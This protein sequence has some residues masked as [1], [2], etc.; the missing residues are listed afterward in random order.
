MVHSIRK[1]KTKGGKYLLGVFVTIFILYSLSGIV[2]VISSR[3]NLIKGEGKKLHINEFFNLWNNEKQASYRSDIDAKQVAYINS[4]NFM[5][6]FLNKLVNSKL[7]ELE[8]EKFAIREPD[9]LV[10]KAISEDEFFRVDG[11]F[12]FGKFEDYLKKENLTELDLMERIREIENRKFLVST[13][14]KVP[15]LNETGVAVLSEESNLSKNLKIFSIKKSKLKVNIPVVTDEEIKRYY[16]Y[17]TQKFTAPE[18]KKID[19]VKITDCKASQFRKLQEIVSPRSNIRDVSKAMKASIESL[20]YLSESEILNN[21]KYSGIIG[22]F[23]I[24]LD[25]LSR[26]V[27]VGNDAYVYS[28]TGVKKGYVKNLKEVEKDIALVIRA[29]KTIEFQKKVVLGY[30]EEYKNKKFADEALLSHGFEIKKVNNL[31]RENS[32]SL[33]SDFLQQLMRTGDKDTTDVFQ[34]DS[35]LY[36]ALITDS[37][38]LSEKGEGYVSK[39]QIVKSFVSQTSDIILDHYLNYLRNNK[40]I[41]MKVSYG[42]LDLLM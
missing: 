9:E 23:G 20:G 8:L 17:N 18:A 10:L 15:V 41:K 39:E 35:I 11:G 42:L 36:F 14:S 40:Y 16:D 1:T 37:R 6:A 26:V 29:E 25:S 21:E 24:R 28:V 27:K 22:V 33:D 13:L 31:T 4:K 32:H 5:L 3:Y 12:D 2:F 30:I 38:V 34:D 19:Y 7:V